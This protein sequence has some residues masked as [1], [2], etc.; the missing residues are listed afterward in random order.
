MSQ[1]YRR[2]GLSERLRWH[3]GCGPHLGAPQ[4]RRFVELAGAGPIAD[5]GGGPHRTHPSFL[6]VNL[7]LFPNVD[8]VSDAHHLGLRSNCLAGASCLAVLEHVLEP[9]QVVAE[10]HR[11]LRPRGF[12]YVEVPFIQ[13]FHAFP[14][15][16]WRYTLF[17]LRHLLRGFEELSAGV[18]IGAGAALVQTLD[19]YL[20]FHLRQAA[21]RA[22]IKLPLRLISW[23]LRCLDPW[24]ARGSQ[25]H[26]L[27]SAY[28]FL[29]RKPGG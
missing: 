26:V 16:Y 4:L 2:P 9:A 15:D 21:L 19:T 29:G 13:P 10:L 24:L 11:I 20:T 7:A 5:V 22:A 8:L 14:T 17:G 18:V 3:L 28:Y 6:T 25:G 23:P 27:A 12:V 1:T